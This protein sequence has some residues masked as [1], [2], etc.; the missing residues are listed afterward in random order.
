MR[1][2]VMTCPALYNEKRNP[3]PRSYLSRTHR[4]S[5]ESLADP[6]ATSDS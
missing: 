2:N 3:Q 5:T 1:E 4:T 6:W